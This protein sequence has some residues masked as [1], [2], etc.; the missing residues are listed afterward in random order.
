MADS[1][2]LFD[3]G[4][5]ESVFFAGTSLYPGEEPAARP[6][7]KAQQLQLQPNC[8]YLIASPLLWYGI[9][10]LLERAP[11]SARF[12]AVECEPALVRIAQERMP[13][14]LA[15]SR[16]IRF[17]GSP[18]DAAL[19]AELYRLDIQ[20]L[21][22][23]EIVSLNGGYR[24]QRAEYARLQQLLQGEIERFWRHKATLVH[25]MPLWVS[26]TFFNLALHHRSLTA[27]EA[28][29]KPVLVAG[30]GPSL[31]D[32]LDFIKER[33]T[34][35]YILAVD[36][37]YAPLRSAGICPDMV[38]LQE[39]QYYNQYDFL[40]YPHAECVICADLS[41]HSGILRRLQPSASALHLL[42]TD[43]TST[44]LFNRLHSRGLL[45]PLRVPPLGSVGSTAVYT[46]LQLTRREVVVCGVDFAFP[47]G[48][49]HAKGAVSHL[50]GLLKTDRFHPAA[51]EL[52]KAVAGTRPLPGSAA[53]A[54]SGLP[55]FTTPVIE[56]YVQS[57]ARRIAEEPQ[58]FRLGP[59]RKDMQ[60][61]ELT[62]SDMEGRL[63]RSMDKEQVPRVSTTGAGLGGAEAPGKQAVRSFLEEEGA[64]LA[65]CYRLG[66][67][68]LNGSGGPEERQQFRELLRRADYLY[69]YFPDTGTEPPELN[70]T[71][72]KRL[73]V[74][75]GRFEQ[76]VNK[77]RRLLQG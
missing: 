14:H 64:L 12:L 34:Q 28:V 19:I 72:L 55:L 54:Q 18:D 39:A 71:M 2:R 7:S 58:V 36:T 65:E 17:P 63:E 23:C 68:L 22:R 21:R 48:R 3:A 43:F 6:R 51:G 45:P 32:Y 53:P 8:L 46:A 29:E 52:V 47:E 66:R 26:N 41:S 15:D 60:L 5:G 30:A 13:R 50:L 1:P 44:M 25:M 56:S 75:A 24:L 59:G 37:A 4:R 74:S 62:R 77:A 69:L 27:P 38:L 73:L 9:E 31:D 11:E 20:H 42:H 70:P 10:T 49:T 76:Q 35:L 67:K 57:F 40:P 61:P 16:K 33:R